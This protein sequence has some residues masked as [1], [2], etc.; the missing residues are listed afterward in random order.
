[1][2]CK[3]STSAWWYLS[4]RLSKHS[5]YNSRDYTFP[6]TV[7][8]SRISG[9]GYKIGPVCLSV[10]LSVIQRSHGQT[11]WHTDSECDT[12]MYQHNISAKFEGQGRHIIK[13]NFYRQWVLKGLSGKNTSK[14]GTT[15]EGGVN[16][17][18]F[19][20]EIRS[21]LIYYIHTFLL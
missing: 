2:D 14:E 13:R 19:S 16:A 12:G 3:A 17:Q 7:I 10:C 6:D 15:R 20:L 18:A 21:S 8:P 9:R 1:M 5:V 4:V 11:V